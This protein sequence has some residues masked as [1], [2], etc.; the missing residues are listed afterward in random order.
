MTSS[1]SRAL[2]KL[3]EAGLNIAGGLASSVGHRPVIISDAFGSVGY[4]VTNE[5]DGVL[6]NKDKNTFVEVAAG[7]NCYMMITELPES[8]Q[9]VDA[10]SKFSG[11]EVEDKADSDQRRESTGMSERELAELMQSND[12]EKVRAALPRM[13]PEMR[14]VAETVLSQ[15]VDR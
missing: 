2:A 6:T 4:R 7:T 14:R 3:G 12:P 11:R 8:I 10:L 5:F 9:G 15:G 13:S 1:W